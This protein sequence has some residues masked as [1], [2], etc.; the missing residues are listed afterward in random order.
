MRRSRGFTLV[1]LLVV[2]AI[3]GLLAG[4]LL[5]AVSR[6][7]AQ[8]KIRQCQANLKDMGTAFNLYNTTY[9][10]FPYKALGGAMK[11]ANLVSCKKT[12]F[13]PKQC[14]CPVDGVAIID[15]TGED[16]FTNYNDDNVIGGYPKA[17]AMSNGHMS[18]GSRIAGNTIP[19]SATN[20]AATALAAGND[21]CRVGHGN[22]LN[23]LFLDSHVEQVSD[24]DTW[25]NGT[26]TT[27]DGQSVNLNVLDQGVEL[28]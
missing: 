10:R 6:V 4:L 9:G 17:T 15:S 14:V 28:N 19:T 1:E 21:D 24:T 11:I 20:P 7:Q 8:A 16:F 18:Y 25:N 2:I 3:I 5:P 22:V 12:G 13:S 23:V 27:S 26:N